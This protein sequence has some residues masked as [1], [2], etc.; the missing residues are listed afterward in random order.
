MYGDPVPLGEL[1][2]GLFDRLAAADSAEP[3]S[4]VYNEWAAVP[5][6]RVRKWSDHYRARRTRQCLRRFSERDVAQVRREYLAGK[7]ASRCW[8]DGWR[9]HQRTKRFCVHVH[10]DG[11]TDN[12]ATHRS[13]F[14]PCHLDVYFESLSVGPDIIWSRCGVAILHGRYDC[15]VRI[16]SLCA[17]LLASAERERDDYRGDRRKRDS[18]CRS[19]RCDVTPSARDD[20]RRQVVRRCKS[21]R[22]RS[23][24]SPRW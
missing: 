5:A 20:N 7:P 8:T 19:T 18:V 10:R 14:G 21:R 23:A 22:W 2:L 6:V 4:R 15:E 13:V 1:S 11:P 9:G 16:H 3:A 24:Q 12:R 17:H